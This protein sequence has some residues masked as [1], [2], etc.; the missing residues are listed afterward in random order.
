MYYYAF[1]IFFSFKKYTNFLHFSM[2]AHTFNQ[3]IQ[4]KSSKHSPAD[5][6]IKAVHENYTRVFEVF[7]KTSKLF[8]TPEIPNRSSIQIYKKIPYRVKNQFSG[9]SCILFN[10][11]KCNNMSIN[12]KGRKWNFALKLMMSRIVPKERGVR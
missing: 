7:N 11:W 6:I 5:H 9:T 3:S 4:M 10:W 8:R 2:S 12:Y 1:N